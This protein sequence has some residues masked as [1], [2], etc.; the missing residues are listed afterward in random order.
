MAQCGVRV[1]ID[2]WNSGARG[3]VLIFQGR[4][5]YAEK[6]GCAAEMF[7]LQGYRCLAIDSRGQGFAHRLQA[8]PILVT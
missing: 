8:D 2:V 5:E 1:R 7:A 4:T 3:I 6:Y